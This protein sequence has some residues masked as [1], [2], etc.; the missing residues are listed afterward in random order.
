MD[1]GPDAGRG[2]AGICATMTSGGVNILTASLSTGLSRAPPTEF[3]AKEPTQEQLFNPAL[4]V[5]AYLLD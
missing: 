1:H 5:N 4:F 3:L 2:G